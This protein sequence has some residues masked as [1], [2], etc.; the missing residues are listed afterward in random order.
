MRDNYRV[1]TRLTIDVGLRWV[2]HTPFSEST[3]RLDNA[4]AADSSGAPMP[5]VPVTVFNVPSIVLAQPSVAGIPFE[6]KQW[7]DFAPSV[8]VNWDV[9]GRGKTVLSSGYSIAYDREP[10]YY[11]QTLGSNVPFV[12]STTIQNLPFGTVVTPGTPVAGRPALNIWDPGTNT[13][14]VQSWNLSLQQAIAQ[15]TVVQLSYIGNKGTHLFTDLQLNRGSAFSGSRPNPNYSTI[16]QTG[17]DG[18][19]N[20]RALALQMRQEYTKNLSLQ[21]VYTYSKSF[22]VASAANVGSADFPVDEYNRRREYG[23]SSFDRR[24]VFTGN[25]LYKLPFGHERRIGT[26]SSGVACKLISDWQA[27]GIFSVMSGQVFSLLAGRDAN[28]DGVLNDRAFIVGS[29]LRP[30]LDR[31]GLSR[32]QYLN[33]A[34]VGT[35]V[36]ASGVEQTMRNG[37]TGPGFAD[38]DVELRKPIRLKEHWTTTFLAQAFNAFNRANFTTLVNTVSSPVFGQLQRVVGNPRV[39]QFSL[40]LDF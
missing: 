17:A 3:G 9:T 34:A 2:Y 20:Y 13:P 21:L 38:V 28:G 32:T 24:H 8:G 27:S 26:C 19:S 5:D 30:L 7:K 29:S 31:T 40:R 1:S 12:N 37:F 10:M 15:R 11:L 25:L 39:F 6:R 22:D 35:A 23:P 14:Y 16:A 18:N 36:A 33:P 4:Y